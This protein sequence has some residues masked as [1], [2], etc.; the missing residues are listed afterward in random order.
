MPAQLFEF[1]RNAVDTTGKD[2]REQWAFLNVDRN[3]DLSIIH[4]GSGSEW[5]FE[6]EGGPRSGFDLTPYTPLPRWHRF[7]KAPIQVLFHTHPRLTEEYMRSGRGL[8]NITLEYNDWGI[9][10]GLRAELVRKGFA[11]IPEVKT[12]II[13]LDRME[14]SMDATLPHFSG[15][16]MSTFQSY[17]P[18]FQS[19]LLGTQFGY[20]WI[21]YNKIS[22]RFNRA[23]WEKYSHEKT[24]L[25]QE[26]NASIERGEG[27]TEDYHQKVDA[28]LTD[29]CTE[30]GAVAFR[31]RD[32]KSPVLQRIK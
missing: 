23:A 4:Q 24:K 26:K 22:L 14:S 11:S 27:L 1:V 8:E 3:K 29:F 2:N 25:D 28:V 21:M 30:I 9:S 16:D 20:L 32:Y 5:Q 31:N 12:K 13:P 6:D 15:Q 18:F 17:T 19:A 7:F 10:S